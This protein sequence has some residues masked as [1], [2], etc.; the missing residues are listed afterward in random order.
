M[1][2]LFRTI[3]LVLLFGAFAPSSLIAQVKWP[4]PPE[5][6]DVEFRYRIK[7]GRNERIVQ[8]QEMTK[9][10]K[11]LGFKRE[12][13]DES[14]LDVF[15]PSAERMIGTIPS[16]NARTLLSEPHIETVLLLP[17]GYKPPADLKERVKVSLMLTDRLPPSQQ[18]LFRNQIKQVL[19]K[20]GFQ[21]AV[22]Y[23]HRGYAS[24]RGTMPWIS[25]PTLLKDLR[26]QPAGWFLPLVHEQDLP[27]P[28]KSKLPIRLIEVMPEEG[29]PV[30]T[31]AQE[32]LPLPA[33]DQPAIA[34]VAADVR[35][36]LLDPAKAMTPLRVEATLS[37]TPNES[38]TTWR[39][40]IRQMNPATAIEGLLGDVVTMT[41]AEGAQ[42][43]VIARLPSILSIR[44]PRAASGTPTTAKEEPK[45]EDLKDKAAGHFR[46][47]DA[48]EPF[49][50]LKETGLAQLHA[51]GKLGTGIRI[52]VIATDFSGW[53]RVVGKGLPKSTRYVDLTAERNLEI[54]PEPSPVA[55]GELGVGTQCALAV[56]VGAPDADL[57]LVRVSAEAP[58]QVIT[59]YRYMLG[60]FFQPLS[61]RA[62]REEL[63]IEAGN[64]RAERDRANAEYRKAFDDFDDDEANRERK[65]AAKAAIAAVEQKEQTL[66]ARANRLLKLEEDLLAVKGA[67]VVLNTLAWNSAHP[68]DATSSLSRFLDGKMSVGRPNPAINSGKRP[69][70]TLWVQPAG[71]TR[72][73]A[74][75]G[76]FHDADGNGLMEFAPFD[77]PL[78][79]GRWTPELNFL[80]L[81]SDMQPQLRELPAGA[82]I[83]LSIQWREPHD[84]D[85][86]EME[87]R[88]PIAPLNLTLFRQ[89]DPSGEKLPSDEMELIARSEGNPQRLLAE[90][91]FGVYEH[92]IEV[93]LPASGQYALRVEGRHPL[94]IRPGGSLGI[95]DQEIRW[96]LKPRIFVD[97]VDGLG[98]DKGR[99]VFGDYESFLG[100]V[101]VPADARTVVTVG[102]MNKDRRPQPYS[103]IGAGLVSDLFI[104]PEVMMYD[105]IP[106]FPFGSVT[107]AS[108]A[109]GMSASLLSAGAE[110]ANFLQYL[111]IRP[112]YPFD[113]PPSW[114]R[115]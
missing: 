96:E 57:V 51:Q 114:L 102:A 74:W 41:V 39:E 13:N 45:K 4:K 20:I 49:D 40:D 30:P 106:N 59:A 2:V 111:R 46:L 42:L 5:N 10:L 63:D 26:T 81:R 18:Q 99:I 76:E 104:K 98:R 69:H 23:D 32:T 25:V 89:R 48:T 64:V 14:D 11:D 82:R 24:L 9:F 38:D 67:T 94:G 16:A 113:V 21:D 101:G 53:Q 73:Q 8:F 86:S 35:R 50:A 1:N 65:R 92:T 27:E 15:D 105:E 78:K 70:P 103:Q 79:A 112:G 19:A 109:T 95:P 80:A 47:I 85:I 87:Y 58:Y 91:E 3:G 54:Q 22:A 52:A 62:R 60:D 84:P 110:S 68:L 28:F 75:L 7:A 77:A 55:Q 6:Y 97:V 93:T 88:L 66:S 100:G 108:I 107:A 56:R 33:P 71:D 12:E 43:N 36:V 31:T 34:K 29:A 115:K 83:R 37:F 61:F 90:R 72:G 17:A 44:L